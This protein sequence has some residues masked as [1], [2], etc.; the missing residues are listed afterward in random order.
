M[1]NTPF[2]S[3]LIVYPMSTNDIFRSTRSHRELGSLHSDQECILRSATKYEVVTCS[4]VPLKCRMEATST[5]ARE[6]ILNAGNNGDASCHR[7]VDEEEQ[8]QP[9]PTPEDEDD[10]ISNMLQE[11]N[12]DEV[13]S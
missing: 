1:N 5:S 10:K 11:V 2:T 7:Q 4:E 9:V 12:A 3:S 13:R 6:R 8:V